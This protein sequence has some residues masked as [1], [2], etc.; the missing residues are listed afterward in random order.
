MLVNILEM[1]AGLHLSWIKPHLISAGWS[2]NCPPHWCMRA[3]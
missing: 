2:V 3:I 1:S